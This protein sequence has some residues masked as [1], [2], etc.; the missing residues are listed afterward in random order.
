M[1]NDENS[2]I[3]EKEKQKD[4]SSSWNESPKGSTISPLRFDN[5]S[6]L[7]KQKENVHVQLQQS[8]SASKNSP[9]HNKSPAFKNIGNVENISSSYQS[10]IQNQNH[11]GSHNKS[12]VKDMKIPPKTRATVVSARRVISTRITHQVRSIMAKF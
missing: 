11:S 8:F 3:S 10:S 6:D 7:Y 4:F 5:S 2:P 12:T 9:Y 1:R